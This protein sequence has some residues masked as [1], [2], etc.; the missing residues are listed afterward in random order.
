MLRVL[1]LG[2]GNVQAPQSST[3]KHC[4][5]GLDTPARQRVHPHP[6]P[7]RSR[8]TTPST[9]QTPQVPMK[10]CNITHEDPTKPHKPLFKVSYKR[11]KTPKQALLPRIPARL[12]TDTPARAQLDSLPSGRRASFSCVRGRTYAR[13]CVCVFVC[14]FVCLFFCLFVFFFFFVCVCVCGFRVFCI[15]GLC[16][17]GFG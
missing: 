11:P 12:L 2:L 15:Y 6:R 10:P 9:S 14:L 8:C 3:L 13:V 4:F 16:C 5:K 7:C 1:C 17:F